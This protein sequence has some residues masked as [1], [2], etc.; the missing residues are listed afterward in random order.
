MGSSRGHVKPKNYKVSICK[1]VNYICLK[2][3][4]SHLGAAG[5]AV[6]ASNSP[7]SGKQN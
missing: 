1:K 2:G 3:Y 7:A 5:E 4:K 6:L